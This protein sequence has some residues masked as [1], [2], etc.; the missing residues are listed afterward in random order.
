MKRRKLDFCLTSH[1]KINPQWIKVLNIRAKIIKLSEENK[2][3]NF[4]TLDL[5]MTLQII[6]KAWA[7]REKWIN[8]T[9]SKL[10]PFGHQMTL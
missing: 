4:M 10:K 9:S 2:E 3:Q 6:L 7:T 5:A 8:W 1:I